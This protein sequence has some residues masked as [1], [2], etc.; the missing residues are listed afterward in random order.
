MRNREALQ[1]RMPRQARSRAT[2]VSIL[3]AALL[4]VQWGR[5]ID[6]NTIAERAGVSIG[7]LYQYF[8]H[9]EAILLAAARR[10]LSA[11]QA[12]DSLKMLLAVLA[13]TLESLLVVGVPVLARS[14]RRAAPRRRASG[15]KS[16][17]MFVPWFPA[18]V[19]VWG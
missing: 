1:R 14:A 15:T 4:L 12:G 16:P 2:V 7:T 18:L 11:A 13:D 8:P 17:S 10:A 3:E 6:T 19:R 5:R 9:K